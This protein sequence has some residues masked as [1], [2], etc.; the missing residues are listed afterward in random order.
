MRVTYGMS[1]KCFSLII[2]FYAQLNQK[3]GNY[4]AH[5]LGKL[6]RI[7]VNEA[8]RILRIDCT[9]MRES[10]PSKMCKACLLT[11]LRR[12]PHYI[13][14]EWIICF[15]FLVKYFYT[16]IFRSLLCMSVLWR[17]AASLFVTNKRTLHVKISPSKLKFMNEILQCYLRYYVLRSTIC[18]HHHLTCC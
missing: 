14:H 15:G 8:I 13:T 10:F 16:Q 7:I 9:G 18:H 3:C 5:Y 11:Y 4:Q 6:P 12:S 2:C 1:G 17:L